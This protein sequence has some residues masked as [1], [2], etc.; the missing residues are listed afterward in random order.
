LFYILSE[1]L[2]INVKKLFKGMIDIRY[3]IKLKLK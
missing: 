3:K 2:I 1:Q